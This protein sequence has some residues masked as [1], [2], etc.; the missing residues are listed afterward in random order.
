MKTLRRLNTTGTSYPVTRRHISE[1]NLSNTAA[2]ADKLE[3][4]LVTHKVTR[5]VSSK[6][7]C[8]ST[9]LFFQYYS[10]TNYDSGN[11]KDTVLLKLTNI[12]EKPSTKRKDTCGWS[13]VDKLC[14]ISSNLPKKKLT[15]KQNFTSARTI[16]CTHGHK[17]DLG[18][19]RNPHYRALFSRRCAWVW[20]QS[21]R[22]WTT[23][24]GRSMVGFCSRTASSTRN[25]L[26]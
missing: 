24:S 5:W 13:A 19:I 7:P 21:G 17:K 25:N 20:K 1:E 6:F 8:F 16:L 18:I 12:K 23:D 22:C 4:W 15:F 10:L 14:F 2:K 11:K 3:I 9:P 26:P